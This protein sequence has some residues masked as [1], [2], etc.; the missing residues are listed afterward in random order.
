VFLVVSPTRGFSRLRPGIG[1]Q[2]DEPRSEIIGS[3][4]HADWVRKASLPGVYGLVTVSVLAV[5]DGAKS[6]LPR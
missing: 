1:G 4:R 3:E 2:S 6:A 5:D